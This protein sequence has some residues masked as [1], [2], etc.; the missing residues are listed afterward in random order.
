MPPHHVL[1]TGTQDVAPRCLDDSSLIGTSTAPRSGAEPG[2]EPHAAPT[3]AS[4][5]GA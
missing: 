2:A 5:K 1:D 3:S 4:V